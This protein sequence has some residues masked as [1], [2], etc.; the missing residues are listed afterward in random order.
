MKIL[1]CC[2][3]VNG[4]GGSEMYHYELVRELHSLGNNVT[5]F[6]LRDI[7]KNDSVRKRIDELGIRQIDAKTLDI[8]EKFDI[9]LASQPQVNA[10][11]IQYFKG[12][13]LISVIH[14]EI[15][16]ETPILDENISHY[17]SIRKPITDML[18]NEYGIPK[19]KIS[20]IYNPI[21]QSRFNSEGVTKNEKTSGIFVGEVLDPIRFK[22]V[23]HLVDS[24]IE[25]DWDLY[26]MSNSKH[27][28]KH[29]NI[30]YINTRWDTENVVKHMDFTAGILLGRTTLEGWCCD[31][32]GYIYLIDVNGN[33]TE[34]ETSQP[35]NIKE[36]CNSRYVANQHIEL[37]KKIIK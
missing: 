15:R 21:D 24:C 13:P 26:L 12:T 35:D 36:M 11:I 19:D 1:V 32:P 23:S 29:S 30:K 31:V 2:L 3:N 27:D 18:I 34:I 7:D 22:A 14:S 5:L 10:F 9:I 8:N 20:L 33:L 4:F 37:Y 25:N 16:S 28:F 6:S 17:I